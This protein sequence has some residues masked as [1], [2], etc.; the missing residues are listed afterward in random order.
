MAIYLKI[1]K[2]MFLCI[3]KID[4]GFFL[5]YSILYKTIISVAIIFTIGI[6]IKIIRK[7]FALFIK[8]IPIYNKIRKKFY[9]FISS[10]NMN[11]VNS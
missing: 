10:F 7:L 9:D 2:I 6:L 5:R 11:I 1:V 3:F 4:T 8:K